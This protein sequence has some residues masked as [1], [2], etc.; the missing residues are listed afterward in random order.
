MAN[1]LMPLVKFTGGEF[2]PSLDNRY[3]LE[4]YRDGCR[5][6]TNVIPMKQGGAQRRPGTQYASDGGK[7]GGGTGITAGVSRLQKFQYA[8]GTAFILEFCDT[9]IRFFASGSLSAPAAQVT[10]S[11]A[12]TWVSGTSYAW[13]AFVT[14]PITSLIYYNF[15]SSYINS[16][17]DPSVDTGRWFQ[18]S[19]YEVPAPYSG[20][21]FTAPDYWA[22]D[23]FVLQTLQ[24]NDVMYIVHPNFPVWK[25]TRYSNTNW[26]MQQVQFIT[27]AMMDENATDE[28]LTAS[29]T[30]GSMTLTATANA[31]WAN[32]TVYVPGNT[33]SN[34]GLIYSCLM[35]HTS[36]ATFTTDLANGLWVL[37]TNFVAGHVG[38]Y[39]QLAYNRP[40]SFIEFDAVAA[41]PN[42]TFLAGTWYGAGGP[43]SLYLVGTWEVQ[44]YGTWTGDVTIK[45]SY[46][47]GSTFQIITTLTS[48]GDA[49]YSISGQELSGGIYAFT[50]ANPAAVASSTPPRIVLTA[51]NQFIYGLVQ[52]TA[53]ASAYSATASVIGAPLYATTATAFWSEGAWSQYRGYPQAITVFQERVW[54]GYSAAEPQRVWATQTDDIENFALVDQ[55]QATY[56]LAFDL[57]AA[58]RGPIQWLAAQTDLFA[59]L[60]SAEWVLSSGGTTTAITATAIQALEH[61]VNGSAPALPGFIIGQAA[62]YVQRKGRSFQQMMFSVFTNKYMSQ[63]M[64]V[65]SQ[66][67]TNAGIQQFD[68]QQQFQEQSILW[69]ICGDGTLI[70]MTYAID[71]K[72]FAWAKHNTGVG[73][74]VGF[75]SVQVIY[76][77]AGADD[78]VWVSVYRAGEAGGFGPYCSIERLNPVDWQTYNVGQPQLN[79]GCWS[80]CSVAVTSPGSNVIT[81]IPHQLIGR[82]VVASIVPQSNAGMWAIRNL[83]VSNSQT[84]TIP[85]YVPVAGDVVTVGLP[86]NWEIM[87]M[88]LD[89]DPRQGPTPGQTKSIRQ[90]F[91][92]TL[93]SIG[94][95][96]ATT[97]APPILGT[98]SVVND[99]Q[100][101]PIN[102]FGG[103]PP[104]F[105]PNIPQDKEIDVGGL[106]GYSLDPEFAVV[107]SD[108]LPFFLL[109]IAIKYDVGGRT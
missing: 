87:P 4:N 13:G 30:T 21:N 45:V 26:V 31:A 84:V 34:A 50:V 65:T 71:Q 102:T 81:G 67:L 64:Q 5:H 20:A 97:A 10:L 32:A 53:V 56:G 44:T 80:D 39:W 19:I 48:R 76:G 43:T 62:F 104:P 37:V 52:I 92:R 25:L 18:Q 66:H 36:S 108:P 15:Y 61:T 35:A 107:G 49:N 77:A 17:T 69:A 73:T 90:L 1:S 24:I 11:S 86:V 75:L 6:L 16:T 9:G 88:R 14:S 100:V 98:L 93:N 60:A 63:D 72:V 12:P 79:V 103:A 47:N 23:V 27:P 8:P 51:D 101:Y 89:V 7:G 83:V 28:T 2:S 55:S 59:G 94:G 42:Y 57:N 68:Y 58:G 46:D 74:D 40:T 54:Y 38:S 33:V 106:F 99:I 109:G 95:Q 29:A 3:D 96:W 78:E 85:N 105:T 70:S 91:L 41:G 22:A 82:T